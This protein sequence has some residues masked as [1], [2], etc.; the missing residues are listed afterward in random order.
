[1]CQNMSVVPGHFC[2]K[3]VASNNKTKTY[4]IEAGRRQRVRIENPRD[5][6]REIENT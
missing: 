5:Y 2:P 3:F 4:G 6:T 1:M